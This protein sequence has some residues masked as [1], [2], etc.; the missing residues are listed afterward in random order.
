MRLEFRPAVLMLLVLTVVTGVAYPLLITGV[1]QMVFPRQANGSLILRDRRVVG[2][3]RIGQPFS[4]PQYFWG[5]LS[6]TSPPYNAGASSGSNLGPLN[7][8]RVKAAAARI[9]ALCAADRGAPR[10]VPIDLVTA[11]A[12]GLDPHISLA[13]AEYQ[14]TR[15]AEA[16][17]ASLDEIRRLIS[18]HTTGRFLG[19]LGEPIVNVLELNLDLD[20]RR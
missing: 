4:Q 20:T 2:S 19:I 11:S 17:K 16:R 12:S 8:A 9:A 18:K 1:S 7:D 14:A 3:S 15:V 10:A 13:A 6:A 5:R